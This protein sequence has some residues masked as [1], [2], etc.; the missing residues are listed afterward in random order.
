M[1]DVQI[2]TMT[3]DDT[4]QVVAL[5]HASG[6]ARPWNDPLRDISF[7]RRGTHSTI[8]VAERAGRVVAT[9]MLGDDGHRGWVHY[10]AADPAQQGS[11][12]GRAIMEAAENWLAARGVWK[13]QL[14]V[15]EDNAPVRKF[16]EHLGYRD[17]R[18]ICLQKI[19]ERS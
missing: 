10:V 17:T 2:R 11:G 8:L 9:A 18:A 5:W 3:D 19:I 4:E 13:V 6:V 12:L 15:R 1:T 7:A 14:L 16:Y